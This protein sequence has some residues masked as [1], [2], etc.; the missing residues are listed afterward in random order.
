M[1]KKGRLATGLAALAVGSLVAMLTGCASRSPQTQD[2]EGLKRAGASRTSEA[3]SSR[4]ETGQTPLDHEEIADLLQVEEEPLPFDDELL[5]PG[6]VVSES[7]LDEIGDVMAELEPERLEAERELVAVEPPEF[8]IPMV[9]NDQVL[10]WIDY[11]TNR[12]RERFLPGMAR[13]GRYIEMFREIFAEHG[14]PQDLVYMAHVESAF[15][16]NAYSR[17][18]AMG[19]WQFIAST[20]RIYDLKIDYWVD[21]RRD[22]EKAAHAAAAYLSK[23]YN[24]F[25]DWYLAMAAYN[26]GEGRLRRAIKGTG[27]K[28]F[29]KIRQTRYLRR[30]TRNYVPAILAAIYIYKDPEKY[31]MVYEPDAIFAYDTIQVEGAVDLQVL[32]E[33]AGSDFETMKR[34]NTMLRRAQTP[35]N[36]TTDIRVPVGR[37]ETTLAALREVPESKR[38]LYVRHRVRRGDTMYDLA[39]RYGVSVS[40]IQQANNMGRRTMIR[41]GKELVIPTVAA[42]RYASRGVPAGS[43]TAS[44]QPMTYRVRRGDTLSHIARR[45]NTSASAVAV[46]SGISVHSTLHVGDRLTVVPGV[47]SS[48]QARQI[49]SGRS[50]SGSQAGST[51]TVRRGESLWRIAQMYRTTITQLCQLN[52]ISRNATLYPGTTLTVASH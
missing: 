33:C 45:Y 41:E 16:T 7:P 51:H 1:W 52:Q 27:T 47:R 8:D 34:F 13:S 5:Q 26:A 39:R 3:D 14:L 31:G 2:P 10:F 21:E 22:P 25:G 24:E 29:W 18:R 23:L 9:T 30:E 6:E 44:G 36:A 28:D 11:Y 4:S 32:S 50:T 43:Y 49:A 12:H 38:V 35:P 19:V 46:V 42:G 48:T 37:G 15:K 40:A 17:A 20:A